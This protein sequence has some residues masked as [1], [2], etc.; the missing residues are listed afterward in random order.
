MAVEWS[1]TA[2]EAVAKVCGRS[3]GRGGQAAES[4]SGFRAQRKWAAGRN[5][6][7]L[8]KMR[9]KADIELE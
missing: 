4:M 8:S 7:T 3:H 2:T 1:T 6:L 5:R 9:P